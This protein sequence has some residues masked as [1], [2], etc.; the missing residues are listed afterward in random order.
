V[1]DHLLLSLHLDGRLAG[2]DRARLEERLRKEP[3]LRQRLE[4]LQALQRL[5]AALPTTQAAFT[6]D[7]VRARP[8]VNLRGWS[9]RGLAAAAAILLLTHAAAFWFGRGDTPPTEVAGTFGEGEAL[10]RR[11]A[12]LGPAIPFDELNGRLIDLRTG[13]HQADLARR[14]EDLQY[15]HLPDAQRRRLNRL[16]DTLAH[17]E[18][19]FESVRDPG[20]LS[21]VVSSFA[22]GYLE[23]GSFPR[24]LPAGTRF[25][26]S[27]SRLGN[28]RY[29]L[30]FI[31]LE[32]GAPVIQ[33][34]E[35]TLEELR[36]KHEGITFI[37]NE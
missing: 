31:N 9:V 6:A 34:D 4:K 10:L 11:A 28:D 36:Q 21:V 26:A 32:S 33:E 29:K 2:A 20:F 17:F 14:L 18:L 3:A 24:A 12:E 16:R 13:I 35:G 19:A 37:R 30:V 8:P 25:Y 7:Q 5:S 15:L 27:T 1:N 23:D 22:R